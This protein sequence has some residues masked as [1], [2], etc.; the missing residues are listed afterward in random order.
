MSEDELVEAYAKGRISRRVFVRQLVAGGAS[1]ATALL[2]SRALEPA[3][4]MSA[5]GQAP[6]AHHKPR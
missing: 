4:A 1:V 6:L 2:Y 5:R 3:S